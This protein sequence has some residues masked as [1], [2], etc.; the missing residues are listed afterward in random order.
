MYIYAFDAHPK[1]SKYIT[2]KRMHRCTCKL[3]HTTYLKD[4][5]GFKLDVAAVVS[6]HVH[7]QFQILCSTDVFGHDCKVVPVQ[8]EFSQ[9]LDTIQQSVKKT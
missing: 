4:V 9:E 5:K 6:Q 3:K 2:F 7:H 8:Q 1:R